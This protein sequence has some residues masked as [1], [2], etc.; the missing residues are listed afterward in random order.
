MFL[1]KANG[2]MYYIL[3]YCELTLLIP[4]IDKV[5]RSKY[6]YLGFFVSPVEIITMRLL[7]LLFGVTL[8]HHLKLLMDISFL[9]WFTYF[10]LGYLFGNGLLKPNCSDK[11]LV[12]LLCGA[13]V[14]QIAEGYLYYRLGEANCGTQ[15]KLS[16]QLSNAVFCTLIFQAVSREMPVK[17]QILK[18]LG[19]ASF[20][21][22]FSH[23]LIISVLNHVPFFTLCFPMNSLVTVVLSCLAVLAGRRLLGSTSKHFAF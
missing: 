14:L 16:A 21:I 10:Y 6:K 13:L 7:P 1:G 23:M 11:K 2:A 15:L 3:V 17:S 9:G 8:P 4:L 22:Y 5:A 19:D 18:T 20:G 12:L